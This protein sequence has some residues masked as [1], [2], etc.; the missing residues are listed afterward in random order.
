MDDTLK[1]LTEKAN[2]ELTL[3]TEKELLGRILWAKG[4]VSPV[5][6]VKKP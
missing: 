6:V 3:T 2:V 1:Q 5:I 4:R